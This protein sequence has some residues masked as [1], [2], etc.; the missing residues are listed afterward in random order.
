MKAN[1]F[2]ASGNNL[3][4]LVHM[5]CH[6]AGIKTWVQIFLGAAPLKF[7]DLAQFWTTLDCDRKIWNAS[8]YW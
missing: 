2:G 6:E 4:K 3:T 1:N 8:R 7:P 5:V